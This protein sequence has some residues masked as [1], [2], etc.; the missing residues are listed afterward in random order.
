MY[1]DYFNEFLKSLIKA[2]EII[3]N[4]RFEIEKKDGI[5]II[6][7][8]NDVNYSNEYLIVS[9]FQGDISGDY[10]IAVNE[11]EWKNILISQGFCDQNT[12]MA[13][14]PSFLREL[15]NSAAGEAIEAIRKEYP[16][17]DISP[18]R[19]FRGTVD[20]KH[21]KTLFGRLVHPGYKPIEASISFDMDTSPF[22]ISFYKELINRAK[23]IDKVR[24]I[25]DFVLKKA[26]QMTIYVDSKGNIISEYLEKDPNEAMLIPNSKLLGKSFMDL[27]SEETRTL[28]TSQFMDW[29]STKDKNEQNCPLP[30]VIYFDNKKLNCFYI[31]TKEIGNVSLIVILKSI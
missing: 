24:V 31:I 17:I 8:S 23:E 7:D 26:N 20:R 29:L 16:K 10:L 25:F 12:A 19:V 2:C 4:M 1:N 14:V 3:F 27:F 18:P 6:N 11:E 28:S 30:N 9:S 5:A 15:L 22:E 13:L 21:S